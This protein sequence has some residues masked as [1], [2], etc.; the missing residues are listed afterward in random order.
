MSGGTGGGSLSRFDAWRAAG[1]WRVLLQL[2]EERGLPHADAAE[3]L[4]RHRGIP[5]EV[6]DRWVQSY[7]SARRYADRIQAAGA[8]GAPAA[9][10]LIRPSG[11][12]GLVRWWFRVRY[13]DDTG[14]VRTMYASADGPLGETVGDVLVRVRAE[15]PEKIRQR[16]ER[17][18]RNYPLEG[19]PQ[20]VGDP[21]LSFIERL[22]R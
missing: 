7:A 19:E 1:G 16:A 6:A 11:R 9:H 20:I 18:S 12:V 5:Q 17:D 2:I 13:T 21:T 22:P 15:F 10:N 4:V 8:Q 14:N 3:W